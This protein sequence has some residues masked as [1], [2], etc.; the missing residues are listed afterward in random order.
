MKQLRCD[1]MNMY[2]KTLA[3]TQ[4]VNKNI[5][6]KKLQIIRCIQQPVVCSIALSFLL[7]MIDVL[8]L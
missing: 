7:P 3:E 2:W 6:D 8:L 4:I 1:W 5:V